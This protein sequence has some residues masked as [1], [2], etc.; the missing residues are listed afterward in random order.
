MRHERSSSPVSARARADLLDAPT[1][2]RLGEYLEQPVDDPVAWRRELTAIWASAYPNRTP[3]DGDWSQYVGGIAR[4]G[5][6]AQRLVPGVLSAITPAEIGSNPLRESVVAVVSAGSRAQVEQAS[7]LLPRIGTHHPDA[8]VIQGSE[9]VNVID[10]RLADAPRDRPWLTSAIGAQSD[11]RA[12]L[13]DLARNLVVDYVLAAGL[14]SEHPGAVAFVRAAAQGSYPS[15]QTFSSSWIARRTLV[16]SWCERRIADG[17]ASRI[18]H[19]QALLPA[20]TNLAM[21]GNLP[22]EDWS[23]DA[24]I[25]ARAAAVL[26]VVARAR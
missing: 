22:N 8:A 10:R 25:Q 19:D 5:R 24:E 13:G 3:A 16:L 26:G 18:A 21:T 20:L 1:E 2:R 7:L 9:L 15:G 17:R 11:W 14:G 6:A 4:L 12:P 23:V